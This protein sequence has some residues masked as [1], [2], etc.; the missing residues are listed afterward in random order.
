MNYFRRALSTSHIS[1]INPIIKNN[2]LPSC[3]LC[4]HF[5]NSESPLQRC[6]KFAIKNIVSGEIEYE[7]AKLCR[8]YPDMCSKMG[9]HFKQIQNT[10]Q[11]AI[12]YRPDE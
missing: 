7:Y 11:H 6:K 5:I 4:I 10:K 9:I 3:N 8:I 12:W 2:H 1:S